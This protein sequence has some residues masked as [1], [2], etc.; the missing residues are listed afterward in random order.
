MLQR[1]FTVL[2]AG[3]FA[4]SFAVPVAA[5]SSN[6]E[7]VEGPG[8]GERST[9]TI[10]PHVLTDDVSARAVAVKRPNSTRWALTLIGIARTDSLGLTLGNESLPIED[11]S[12]PDE[13][14]VGPTRAYLSQ[15]TFLTIADAPEVRLH[16]GEAT[17]TFPEQM[18]TEM[19]QIFDDVL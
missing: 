2:I 9:L 12:R 11:I 8:Q 7:T 10:T 15:E 6:I 3:C 5:Q 16:I 18:R 17:T 4:A 19:Q 1:L 14:E 13:G